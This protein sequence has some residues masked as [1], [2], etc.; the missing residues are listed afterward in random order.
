[1]AKSSSHGFATRAIHGDQRPD[2]T[3][4]AVMT[5]IYATSTFVQSS[6]GKH[7]GW[8]YS[9][10][11]NPTRAAFEAAMA[12]LEGGIRGFAFAFAVTAIIGHAAAVGD[13]EIDPFGAVHRTATAESDEGIDILRSGEGAA[14]FDHARVGVRLEIV[15]ANDVDSHGAQSRQRFFNV[16]RS[17]E[18]AIGHQQRATKSEFDCQLPE[19]VDST[20]AENDAGAG[21]EIKTLH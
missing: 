9:R 2:P 7:T 4:G 16:S 18:P 20:R 3:T 10:S 14:G 11:G 8:E 1:M 17:D 13:E 15:K 6:P 12:N 5:P 19:F 21:L